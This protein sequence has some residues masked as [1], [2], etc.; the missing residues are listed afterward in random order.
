MKPKERTERVPYQGGE[1]VSV[2]DIADTTKDNMDDFTLDF[3][4]FGEDAFE[5]ST[6]SFLEEVGVQEQSNEEDEKIKIEA[7]KQAVNVAKLMSGVT[8]EDVIDIASEIATYL[9][10]Y[11]FK[12]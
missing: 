5:D 1:P 3:D 11:E 8:T 7:L 2:V 12:S 10:F 9:K 4:T 6:N